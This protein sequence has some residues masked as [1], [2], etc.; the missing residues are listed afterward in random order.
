MLKQLFVGIEGGATCSKL[1]VLSG[2][3]GRILCRKH[4]GPTNPWLS[5]DSTIKNI[6]SLVDSARMNFGQQESF[7][8]TRFQ[9]LGL[10]LSGVDSHQIQSK[11]LDS[12]CMKGNKCLANEYHLASDTLGPLE[13]AFGPRQAGCV[14][15]SGT[16]SCA[17][18]VSK[19]GKLYR[20][21]GWGHILSDEG[22]AYH[23]SL[24]L[25]RLIIQRIEHRGSEHIET[26]KY[27][28]STLKDLM[29]RYF[30]IS[31]IKEFMP[32]FYS[33]FNKSNIAGFTKEIAQAANN[34]DPLAQYCFKRAGYYLASLLKSVYRQ[35][36]EDNPK[37]RSLNL[38]GV[39]SMWK[40]WEYISPNFVNNL[41][42]IPFTF[43]TL[44]DTSAIGAASFVARKVGIEIPL[45]RK[46][47]VNIIYKN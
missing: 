8:N 44:K 23:T 20:A 24:K 14:L 4:G 12:L 21:G 31:S 1:V 22:S 6:R 15:I 11:I 27:D 29:F 28:I 17:R 33:T 26:R 7:R 30:K 5:F 16:G 3:T 46:Q 43:H 2:R 40:S 32:L 34:N 42:N 41:D 47:L 38:L 25:I 35:Y 39:G 13:T 45:N 37:P 10:T 18:M 36:L 19:A 9:G